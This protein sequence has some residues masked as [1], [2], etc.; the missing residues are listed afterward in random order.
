MAVPVRQSVIETVMEESTRWIKYALVISSAKG[1]HHQGKVIK[2]LLGSPGT[3]SMASGE[4]MCCQMPNSGKRK[5]LFGGK[6]AKREENEDGGSKG[7]RALSN[8]QAKEKGAEGRIKREKK[9]T[10]LRGR[11]AAARHRGRRCSLTASA[12][13]QQPR[14]QPHCP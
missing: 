10:Y 11:Q 1:V 5:G 7:C 4:R 8:R 13:G 12:A 9:M 2:V 6:D 14:R 3:G